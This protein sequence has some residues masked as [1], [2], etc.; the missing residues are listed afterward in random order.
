MRFSPRNISFSK[1][2]AIL[3]KIVELVETAVQAMRDGKLDDKERQ[4]LMDELY[5]ILSSVL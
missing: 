3:P 2:F 4:L 5:G 1:W